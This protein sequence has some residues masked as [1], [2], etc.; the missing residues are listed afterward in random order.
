MPDSLPPL[1]I[2][3]PRPEG[4]AKA[5][6][7]LAYAADHYAPDM[8][9][10][11]VKRA[12][13]AHAELGE[14]HTSAA[15]AVKG[16]AAVLTHAE[17]K[18][19]NRQGVIRNDQP[20]LVDDRIRHRGD[21]IA[22]VAADSRAALDEALAAITFDY[23]ELPALFSP[24]ESL[25]E[26]AIIIHPDHDQGN[27][28]LSGR[29]MKG[30][31][32]AELERCPHVIEAE[33]DLTW[34][35]HAY[36]ETEAGWARLGED[37]RLEINVSTQTPFR[38]LRETAL[39]LGLKDE[40][41]RIIAPYPGGAF[42]GK[43][44]VTVQ[45]LL[46]L[47]ALACPGRTVKMWTSREESLSASPKRHPAR[48]TYRLGADDDGR[49]RALWMEAV[50]DTGPY[51]HLGGAVLGLGL[52]HA[53]GPYRLPQTD[54]NAKA[55]Y[56]NNPIGGAF[57]GFGV[58]QVAAGMEQAVDLM[59][60]RVGLD[61]A[62]IRRRNIVHRGDEAPSGSKITCSVGL[63]DCLKATTDHPIWRDRAAWKAGAGPGRVRG[64]GLAA[65]FHGLGYGPII[66]DEANAK[67]EL[68]D[69]GRVIVYSGVIDMGQGNA[70]T[71]LQ[72]A[73]QALNQPL[74]DLELVIPDTD[75]TLPSGSASASRTTFT[76]GNAL[77]L[78]AAA[79]KN[80]LLK[81]TAGQLTEA[82]PDDLVLA[83]GRVEHPDS[84]R[85]VSLAEVAAAL[86]AEERV[87][88]ARYQ[89]PQAEPIPGAPEQVTFCGVPH[90]VF[91][92]AVQTAAV[93]IDRLTGRISVRRFL[94]ALDCGR[95]LNPLQ[96]EQQMQGAVAQ[97]LGYALYE[98]LIA[99]QGRI[100]TNDFSTYILP[101]S[102]DLPD[103]ETIFIDGEEETG[104]HGMKGLGEIGLD[105]TLPAVA[106]AVAD[107][108]GARA[109]C[110]PLTPERLLAAL[111]RT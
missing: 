100:V 11:G 111:D 7:R 51:D 4:P 66:P 94:T 106:N 88:T 3:Q 18:G 40:Q 31:A 60:E 75:Q 73:A 20:V 48:L 95:L 57:R 32:L 71:C 89:A 101:T 1:G 2:D 69:Q 86:S 35:E 14:I 56:T 65:A 64:V 8:L 21:A 30:D 5:T 67:L 26:G 15:Q 59:A 29:L 80:R 37:G 96:A 76:Y 9:W 104:P 10:V 74:G 85:S 52:E 110:W 78:A 72:L 82:R 16:V 34:Q 45:T 38:D 43:D 83:P 28:L 17:V 27:V 103:M 44:G 24:A 93:E 97:G 58:P 49:F 61:P 13:V 109:R 90:A 54:L 19:T 25:A 50:F 98:D 46:G 79:F 41:V 39:A 105:A 47:A 36:L 87:V 77:I 91:G 62:E 55:V 84:G 42:G 33:Y 99:D 23:T 107:A 102:L 22:L 6:G 92:F 108:C 81:A 63:A 12:G 68:S 53:G 70:G